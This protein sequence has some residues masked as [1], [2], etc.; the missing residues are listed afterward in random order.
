MEARFG[1]FRA[2][3]GLSRFLDTY[4][5]DVSVKP[6]FGFDGTAG[7]ISRI[8]ANPERRDKFFRLGDIAQLSRCARPRGRVA[9]TRPCHTPTV[10]TKTRSSVPCS[11]AGATY[12]FT[13]DLRMVLPALSG[14]SV[15]VLRPAAPGNPMR[16]AQPF[17]GYTAAVDRFVTCYGTRVNQVVLGADMP[18]VMAFAKQAGLAKV[19]SQLESGIE[20]LVHRYAEVKDTDP[21]FCALVSAGGGEAGPSRAT[22]TSILHR[23]DRETVQAARLDMARAMIADINAKSERFL[24]AFI[25]SRLTGAT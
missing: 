21:V 24:V 11:H 5:F 13:R 9:C 16:P 20:A 4:P 8:L 14:H 10:V 22:V 25:R 18:A 17:S 19:V 2:N 6:E 1:L 12:F 23:R 3:Q 15:H 7:Q